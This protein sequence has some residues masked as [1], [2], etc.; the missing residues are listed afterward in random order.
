MVN[1][2]GE[3]GAKILRLASLAQDDRRGGAVAI[4][5]V[6][7]GRLPPIHLAG[8]PGYM[9]GWVIWVKRTNLGKLDAMTER[10][11]WMTQ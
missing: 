9:A 7:G 1:C 10:P 11:V 4:F 8:R 6:G 2:C 5:C 3:I